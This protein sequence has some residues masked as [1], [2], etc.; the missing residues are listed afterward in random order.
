MQIIKKI[1]A[2]KPDE[3][4]IRVHHK[5]NLRS[6]S[7]KINQVLGQHPVKQQ[8]GQQVPMAIIAE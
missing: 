6:V 7:A 4:L 8:H 1:N 3:F 5:M 2:D